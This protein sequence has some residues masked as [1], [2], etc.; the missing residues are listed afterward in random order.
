MKKLLAIVVLGLLFSSNAK[1]YRVLNTNT[2]GQILSREG[3]ENSK[4]Q[5]KRWITG[6]ITG[7]N[8]ELNA[9]IGTTD[10]ESYYWAI[11]KYCKDNP[12]KNISHA[13]EDLYNQLRKNN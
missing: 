8:Y 1:A 13:A 3:T 2:C 10:Y 9:S 12:L 5:I 6:Y 4:E 7:R 11:V